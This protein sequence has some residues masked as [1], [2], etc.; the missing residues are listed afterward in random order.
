MKEFIE[1]ISRESMALALDYYHQGFIVANKSD[2]L[3]LVTN[4]DIAVSKFLVSAIQ[5]EFPGHHIHSEEMDTDINSGAEYEWVIDPIDGTW[6]FA[7]HIPTWGSLVAVLHNGVT[8]H[9]AAYFPVDNMFYY[10]GLGQGAECNGL[11]IKVSE[12]ARLETST[13][14][15]SAGNQNTRG[16]ELSL[17]WK[18]LYDRQAR[19]RNWACMYGAVL[20]ASGHVDFFITN[21]GKDHDYL[22]PDLLAREAGGVVT[23]TSGV[24]W[25][26]GMQD[27]VIANPGI[28]G[29]LLQLID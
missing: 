11:A 28:H 29:E 23:N 16:E 6:N 25:Q 10:A 18:K 4:A 2:R 8:I 14:S 20:A 15:L 26:R 27:I 13:G 5:A 1:R 19:Q 21:M 12:H 24:P 7:N 17:L 3:D 22:V 9:A